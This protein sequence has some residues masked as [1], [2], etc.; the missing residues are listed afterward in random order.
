MLC[1]SKNTGE[2]CEIPKFKIFF[3]ACPVF[4]SLVLREQAFGSQFHLSPLE[5]YKFGFRAPDPD[6]IG[7][8]G[9]GSENTTRC[10][11][12]YN[13][14]ISSKIMPRGT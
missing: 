1:T 9:I 13:L 3:G 7:W 14:I 12:I 10:G 4:G 8:E 6:S 11:T 2:S 5:P